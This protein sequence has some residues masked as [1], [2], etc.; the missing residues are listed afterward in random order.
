MYKRLEGLH[1]DMAKYFAFDA[2][3]YSIEDFFGDVKNFKDGLQVRGGG[4]KLFSK[5]K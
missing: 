4:K 3:K 1:K 5:Y 2:N